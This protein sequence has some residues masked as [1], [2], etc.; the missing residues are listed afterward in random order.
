[1][2][3]VYKLGPN[4]QQ[5]VSKPAGGYLKQTVVATPPPRFTPLN[6]G[7]HLVPRVHCT[8]D[9][10]D[11]DDRRGRG[12]GRLLSTP[13]SESLHKEDREDQTSFF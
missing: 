1:M 10:A 5:N 8:F 6:V 12:E 3:I 7:L 11:D 2:E 9:A 13:S 4:V